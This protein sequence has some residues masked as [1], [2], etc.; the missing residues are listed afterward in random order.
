MK[1]IA[2][3]NLFIFILSML[4]IACTAPVK[5]SDIDTAIYPAKPTQEE[6]DAQI[7]A[8]FKS[9]L[10]D[11]DSV[12]VECQPVRKGWARQYRTSNAEF[13]WIVAC[14]VNAKNSYGAYVG[15]KPYYFLFT[16]TEMKALQ[17]SKFR[18]LNEHVGYTD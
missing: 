18:E 10:K 1:N 7:Q 15:S 8:H 2:I 6:S 9:T 14:M 3:K 5:Q 12:K 16:V 4:L 11:P 17:S 13:G